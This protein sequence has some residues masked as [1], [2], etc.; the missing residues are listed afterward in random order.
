MNNDFGFFDYFAGSSDFPITLTILVVA[1][2]FVFVALMLFLPMITRKVFPKFGYMRYSDYLPFERVRDD[3]SLQI[4]DGS[5]VRVYHLDGLQT[6][7]QDDATREKF[8][9]LRASLFNQIHDPNVIL[10]FFTTRDAVVENM[11]YEFHQPTLQMIYNKWKSQGLKIF[12][13]NYYVVISVSGNDAADKLDQCCNYLESM[14]AAYKPVL[15]KNNSTNP[16]NVKI[17]SL[18][19]WRLMILIFW[20]MVLLNMKVVGWLN[21]P[22]WFLS[23]LRLII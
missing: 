6:S 4:S 2:V 20:I 8:L 22:Q 17:I 9:D 7:M 5:L 13:N 16:E 18:I 1:V 10:R 14:F 19:W 11:D 21:T 15:L 3:D 23:K 12:S